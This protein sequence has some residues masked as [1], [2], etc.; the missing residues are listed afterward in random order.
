MKIK[1]QKQGQEKEKYQKLL[2]ILFIDF[3]LRNVKR[4]VFISLIYTRR[5]EDRGRVMPE[6]WFTDIDRK[7][8]EHKQIGNTII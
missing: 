3:Q 7:G 8:I 6:N 5:Q 1:Q 2:F 4:K